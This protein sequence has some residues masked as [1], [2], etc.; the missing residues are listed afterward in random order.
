M[1]YLRDEKSN[2]QDITNLNN[3]KAAQIL[4]LAALIIKK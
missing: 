2:E 1:V 4:F 3:K